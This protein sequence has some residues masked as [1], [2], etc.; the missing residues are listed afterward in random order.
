MNRM[1]VNIDEEIL[2]KLKKAARSEGRT[3]SEVF[4]SLLVEFLR[5]RMMIECMPWGH[6]GEGDYG[7]VDSEKS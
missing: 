4:R 1:S 6:R 3:V 5:N 2:A 7:G